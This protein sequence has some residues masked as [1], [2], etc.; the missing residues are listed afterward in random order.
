MDNRLETLKKIKS[1]LDGHNNDV[2][3][4][5]NVEASPYKNYAECIIHEPGKKPRFEN[6]K[7]TPFMYIK[8]LKKLGINLYCG[9]DGKRDNK[10]FRESLELYGIEITKL[11]TGNQKRLEDGYC[12]KITSIIS[13][14]SIVQFLKDGGF[15]IYAKK[16]DSNN[17]IVYDNNGRE[18]QPNRKHIY[19]PRTVEQFFISTGI[20]L[21]KG[22]DEYSQIHKVTFDIETTGLR[23]ESSRVFAIGIR[24]NRG[25]ERVLEVDKWDDNESEKELVAKFFDI[26]VSLKPAIV[27]GYNSEEFDF[28][29]LYGRSE[30][31]LGFSLSSIQTTL[32]N[33]VPIRRIPNMT[34][35]YGNTSEKYTATNLWGISV[36]DINHATK[37]TAAI[38]SDIKNTKLKYICQFED[39]AKPNRTYIKGDDNGIGKMYRDNKI[40][41]TDINNDY[42]E[43]PDKFQELSKKLYELQTNKEIFSDEEYLIERKS[44]LSQSDVA[45]EFVAWYTDKNNPQ[46]REKNKYITGRE[47]LRNYLLDDLWETEQVDELYN[48]SSFM[49]AKII[50]TTYQRV[51]TMGTAAIWDLL[52]T[53]WSYEHDLAIPHPDEKQKFSGGLAR[54]FKK[55]Y[56]ENIYK[57]DY[58]SLYPFAQLTYDIFPVFDIT[59]VLKMMLYYLTTTRNIYKKVATGDVLLDNEIM[60]MELIDKDLHHKVS[61]DGVSDKDKSRS[62]V[63]QLPIKILNNS[64]FGALGSDISFKWSDNKSAARIT[65]IGRLE[66]RHA[67]WWFNKF[68]CTPLM[69]VTDGIN[70]S[71]PNKTTIRV[72]DN[73]VS[74]NQPEAPVKE[75][76]VYNGKTGLE[77][78]IEKF[79]KEEMKPPYM[80][81]DNDGHALS[82]LNLAR[83]NYVM[84]TEKKDKK[85]GELK[86]KIKLTGN[87]TKS[88]TMP[89]YIEDFLNEGLLLL[90]EGKGVEFVEYYNQY[91]TKLY[92]HQI[93]LMKIAS[94]SKIKTNIKGYIN[95][96]TDK[97]GRQKAMQAH[98]EL[99][100]QDREEIAYQIFDERFDEL[101]DDK[102]KNRNDFS[103]SEIFSYVS[104]YM[105]PEP[106]LD[107]TIYYYN[108][109]FRKS[110]G[111]SKEITHPDN[112]N[113]KLFCSKLLH[114]SDINENP[115]KTGYY[116]ADKYLDAFNKRVKKFLVGFEPDVAEKILAKIV[117]KKVKNKD[118]KSVD[119]VKL[120]F[121]QFKDDELRL[122]NF[123]SDTIEEALHLQ[124]KEV[125]F[126]N[127]YG[128]NPKLVW[129]GYKTFKD[130]RVNYFIYE[131][132]LK[133]LNDLM[134]KSGKPQIKRVDDQLYKDDYVLIKDKEI[135]N[136]GRFNGEYTEI[137][138]YDVQVPKT[139]AQ[140]EAEKNQENTVEENTSE[141]TSADKKYPYPIEYFEMFKK[142]MKI[143]KDM[144]MEEVFKA[145]DKAEKY[146]REYIEMI[147]DDDDDGDYDNIDNVYD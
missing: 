128:Y 22:F 85:T 33:D 28:G 100:I 104:D 60:L 67:I 65:C 76:W 51:C 125:E 39:I 11:K 17:N 123:D 47:I 63:K 12:Y 112:P 96:G 89:E 122:K 138:R 93:P 34:V 83:I 136:I 73:E 16:F 21:Y 94:K 49:L 50:P 82:C 64:Q 102:S 103:K 53:T 115:N 36:I 113:E 90:L 105:P 20:R 101:V 30:K 6:I 132:A 69:A 48:Q 29:Y 9:A 27:S 1:F 147:T 110:H 120:M 79:N 77:A 40:H 3:Y 131:N 121:N 133:Y 23:Y 84:L 97:N 41:I 13:Y 134:E 86:K 92:N 130:A 91:V 117:R 95:R 55:G 52:M 44:I 45:N 144:T 14:N 7:Y 24:D 70:F 18:I 126:W 74:Y 139:D 32:K 72:T 114:S 127:N 142:Q 78:L 75:M 57:I 42:E 46:R 98:M 15:D 124:E 80:A 25:F 56:S 137:I 66:L 37:K 106:E 61:T 62:K 145:N 87:T 10:F 59:G 58:A 19:A 119:E 5:V 129:D 135:F 31:K 26:M 38:N 116:N 146:L 43:I 108:I 2:K 118:G 109:G 99:V 54:C 71:V 4:L 107:S 111:D 141:E 81:V 140:I 143:P 68:G 88:K 35:K 8:D